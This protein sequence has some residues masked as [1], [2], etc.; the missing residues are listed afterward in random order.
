MKTNLK[1]NIWIEGFDECVLGT[2]FKLKDGIIPTN[3]IYFGKTSEIP[4]ELASQ[5]CKYQNSYEGEPFYKEYGDITWATYPYET[6]KESIQSACQNEFCI[7]YK[8]TQK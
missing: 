7:I 6:A 1:E 2:Q 4:E 5:C 3:A 8:T